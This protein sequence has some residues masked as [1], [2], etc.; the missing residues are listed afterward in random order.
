VDVFAHPT[1]GG[2][3]WMGYRFAYKNISTSDLSLEAK[4]NDP[5]LNTAKE[6]ARQLLG[7]VIL[8]RTELSLIEVEQHKVL[9]YIRKDTGILTEPMPNLE[10]SWFWDSTLIMDEK[11]NEVPVGWVVTATINVQKNLLVHIYKHYEGTKIGEKT[12]AAV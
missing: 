2:R 1:T 10:Y 7:K 6:I 11:F 4:G 8:N 5:D 9:N 3:P 12:I